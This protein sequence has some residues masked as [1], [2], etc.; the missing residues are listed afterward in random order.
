MTTALITI[1]AQDQIN[2]NLE[3]LT[4]LLLSRRDIE[5]SRQ[6]LREMVDSMTRPAD[7]VWTLARVAALLNPYF[8]KATPQG[9]REIEAEDWAE[10]IRE[11]PQ[12]A[13]ER[14]CRWWKSAD[15][16]ERRKRPLEGDIASRIHK[17]MEPVIVAR[18]RLD[19]GGALPVYRPKSEV[20]EPRVTRERAAQIVAE[21]RLGDRFKSNRGPTQ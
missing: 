16:P 20:L 11:Y 6:D 7:V 13:I 3:L 9:I 10:A 19:S 15:N 4:D 18:K 21:A 5:I 1:T 8:D 14:A 17:E 2:D 12:W